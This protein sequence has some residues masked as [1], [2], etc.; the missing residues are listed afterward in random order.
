[1]ATEYVPGVC[2][3]GPAEIGRR[4]L[5]GV[6]GA[7]SAVAIFV[8]L[9]AARLDPL[10]RLL[11]FLPVSASASGFLQA[12]MKFCT[13]FSMAGVY[14]VQDSLGNIQRIENPEDRKKDREKGLRI[15]G[16]ATAIGAAVAVLAWLLPV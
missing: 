4:R 16:G 15:M 5:I 3:I 7:I 6:I 8:I 2:N 1:M 9:V 10:W 12:A 13:G 14:N 11:I